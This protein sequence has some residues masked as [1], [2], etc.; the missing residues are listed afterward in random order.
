M[1]IFLDTEFSGLRQDAALL[2]IGLAAETGAVFY[3][4]LAGLDPA[5]APDPWVAANVLPLLAGERLPAGAAPDCFMRGGRAAVREAL[6][7]W[8]AQFGATPDSLQLWADVPAWDWVLFCELF[9]GPFGLP[10]QVHY[11]VRDLATWLEQRGI[12]PDTPREQLGAV[13]RRFPGLR[14]AKHHALYDA[15][16]EQSVFERLTAATT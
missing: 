8:L 9:D 2:S 15:L 6:A 1:R 11:I 7:G 3:A 4:E 14:L 16:L 5:A 12:D 13:E 10:P